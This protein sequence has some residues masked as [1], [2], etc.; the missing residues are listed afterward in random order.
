MTLFAMKETK[1]TKISPL[2]YFLIV[3]SQ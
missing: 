1:K 3:I 2:Q